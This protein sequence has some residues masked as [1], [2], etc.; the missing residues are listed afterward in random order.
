MKRIVLSVIMLLILSLPS[1]GQDYSKAKHRPIQWKSY[2][3]IVWIALEIVQT[4]KG[5]SVF[6]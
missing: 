3:R 5:R 2:P 4:V 1:F 6:G